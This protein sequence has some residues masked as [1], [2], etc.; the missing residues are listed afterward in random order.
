M[1]ATRQRELVKASVMARKKEDKKKKGK[2]VASSSTLKVVGKGAPKRKA[3]GKDD[4]PLKKGMV[5]PSD[6]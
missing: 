4:R 2:K 5:T 1:E 6:K 3:K